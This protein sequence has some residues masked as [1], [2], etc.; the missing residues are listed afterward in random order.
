MG[1]GIEIRGFQHAHSSKRSFLKSTFF[2][3]L[4]VSSP[5]CDFFFFFF[6]F[7]PCVIEW[8]IEQKSGEGGKREGE[9]GKR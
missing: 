4:L 9:G 6:S 7:W 2:T 5:N 1:E 8:L 3:R